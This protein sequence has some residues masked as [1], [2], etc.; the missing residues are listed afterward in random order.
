MNP[1]LNFV[2]I[3]SYI[4]L[5]FGGELSLGNLT[6]SV[7]NIHL[8]R[9]VHTEH[10]ANFR[11]RTIDKKANAKRWGDTNRCKFT[12]VGANWGNEHIVT[13]NTLTTDPSVNSPA[14][15]CTL[16]VLNATLSI[17]ETKLFKQVISKHVRSLTSKSRLV[18]IDRSCLWITS[19]LIL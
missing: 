15:P 13:L 7:D 6:L 2:A 14:S 3:N 1:D 18:I 11:G 9:C 17:S 19:M 10:E 8:L 16:Y 12:L 4:L 5:A